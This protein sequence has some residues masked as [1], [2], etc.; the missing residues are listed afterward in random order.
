MDILPGTG[1]NWP[2][3]LIIFVASNRGLWLGHAHLHE[4][5]YGLNRLNSLSRAMT[6]ILRM[7]L[8]SRASS[9]A[10]H[11]GWPLHTSTEWPLRVRSLHFD[12]LSSFLF[13][14]L[15]PA[16]V[17]GIAASKQCHAAQ[18]GIWQIQ[19]KATAGNVMAGAGGA[20]GSA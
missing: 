4:Q 13:L 20:A 1:Y 17:T 14:N 8:A 11:C 16:T 2:T 15:T 12:P 19:M 9:S 5:V 10:S 18:V 7:A 3:R 6:Q